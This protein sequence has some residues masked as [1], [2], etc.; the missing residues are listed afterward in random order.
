MP[1]PDGTGKPPLEE[2]AADTLPPTI[3]PP[4][5]AHFHNGQPAHRA[6]VHWHPCICEPNGSSRKMVTTNGRAKP[7]RMA[8]HDRPPHRR[9]PAHI[10]Q[11]ILKSNV[12]QCV[13][14]AASDPLTFIFYHHTVSYAPYMIFV[15]LAD[16]G[17]NGLV[18][19]AI[20]MPCMHN[21]LNM[22]FSAPTGRDFDPKHWAP[23]VHDPYTGLGNR[24]QHGS[25][26][27]CIGQ[28]HTGKPH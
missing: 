20:S 13:K 11:M 27:C 10:K 14:L 19:K 12:V 18:H 26:I 17:K 16:W 2:V 1:F 3:V 9:N 21:K 6:F 24:L 25:A 5:H 28:T 22:H 4:T 23:R 15:T 8:C 7:A